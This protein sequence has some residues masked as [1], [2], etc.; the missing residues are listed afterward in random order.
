MDLSNW[1]VKQTDSSK[2]F[3]K[4][5]ESFLKLF[6]WKKITI[7]GVNCG[8]CGCWVAR[9]E[10][11]WRKSAKIHFFDTWGLC[12]ECIKGPSPRFQNKQNNK[13]M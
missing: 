7:K 10:T 8:C 9:P 2:N 6:G 1:I 5:K 4:I 12:D 11:I 13:N 3:N